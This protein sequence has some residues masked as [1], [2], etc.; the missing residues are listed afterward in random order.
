MRTQQALLDSLIQSFGLAFLTIAV[1]MMFAV[2][3]VI[4]G[5]QH[6]SNVLPIAAVFGAVSWAG[7]ESTSER[8]SPPRGIGTGCGCCLH[9][10]TWFRRESATA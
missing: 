5:A 6:D 7:F 8:W 10:L 2:K 1:T 3:D 4:A 9:L